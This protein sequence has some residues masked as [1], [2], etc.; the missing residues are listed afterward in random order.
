MCY[1]K[2]MIRKFKEKFIKNK[3]FYKFY[4]Y[5]KYKLSYFPSYGATGEDVLI[6]KIFK[7]KIGFYV[8][9]GAL[10]PINGSNTYL[11]H[12]KGWSGI[13]VDVDKGS[14]DMFNYFRNNDYNKRIA[15]S[16]YKGEI[17]LYTHHDRSAVQTVNKKNAERMNNDGLNKIKVEC[18]TLNS[19]I[20]DSKFKDKKIDLLSIDIE[21]HEFNALKS[22]DFE[23]Y[24]PKV[25]IIEYNDPELI[26]I[27]FHYQKLENI[28]KSEIYK[29]MYKKNYK[30]VNWHHSDLV[31]ICDSIFQNRKVHH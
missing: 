13:N 16:D 10:H 12:K 30:F 20:Q 1:L 31:F 19:I 17:T 24:A 28:M 23:K 22:F 3:L 27:E 15:V 9:V 4:R 5:L 25:V 6:N 26:S 8:D 18:D 21:G 11:L 14:I 7:G 29:L 2:L